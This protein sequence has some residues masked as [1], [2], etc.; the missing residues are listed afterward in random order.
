MARAYSHV[1]W[2]VGSETIVGIGSLFVSG[3]SVI[4]VR[5]GWVRQG[6]KAPYRFPCSG[7]RTPH[8]SMLDRGG[9]TR[10]NTH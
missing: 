3:D 5:L 8:L 10:E 4:K 2:L 7:F 1:A 9:R 6:P